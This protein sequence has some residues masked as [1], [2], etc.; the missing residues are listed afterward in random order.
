MLIA[1]AFLLPS[2]ALATF[3]HKHN[4]RLDK[5]EQHG[6]KLKRKPPE[7]KHCIIENLGKNI[8]KNIVA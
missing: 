8:K 7:M 2:P 3:E 6:V 1:A 5:C 4:A